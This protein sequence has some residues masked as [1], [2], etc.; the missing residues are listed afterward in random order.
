MGLSVLEFARKYGIPACIRHPL[1]GGDRILCRAQSVGTAFCIRRCGRSACL[2]KH[3]IYL[4][5]GYCRLSRVVRSFK[6][7]RFLIN[8]SCS[9][10]IFPVKRL[11]SLVLLRI[12]RG[13]RFCRVLVIC[14]YC[15]FHCFRRLRLL[16]IRSRFFDRCSFDRYF[17]DRRFFDCRLFSSSHFDQRRFFCHCIA[18]RFR[19]NSNALHLRGHQRQR[20]QKRK[21]SLFHSAVLP[22][23]TFT[24][25]SSL[26]W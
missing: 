16:F 9:R 4:G 22:P 15:F 25:R 21:Y 19:R 6:R 3:H 23:V 14:R 2:G 17:F 11:R 8:S 12:L 5:S 13:L 10:H 18:G 1:G 7:R 24:S 26:S 20:Q